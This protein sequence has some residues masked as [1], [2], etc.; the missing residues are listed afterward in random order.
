MKKLLALSLGDVKNITRDSMLLM[1]IF[2]PLLLAV[3]VRFV[4]PLAADEVLERF[5][6]DIREHYTFIMSFIIQLSPFMLGV[7]AGLMIL[8]EKDENILAQIAVTPLSTSGYIAY[9]LL[10][11]MIVSLFLTLFM[12]WIADLVTLEWKLLPIVLLVCMH[13]PIVALFL[14]GMAQN[15]VE[16]LA[17]TKGAGVVLFASLA[18]YLIPSNWAYVA[19]VFPTYWISEAFVA[20]IDGSIQTYAMAVGAGF[21]VSGAY[22]YLLLRKFKT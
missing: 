1:G 17:L 14:G 21:I 22:L 4:V 2:A 19:G 16:G 6:L 13:T 20:A 15:K 5:A 3:F 7:M 18:S 9:R 12:V 8:D 10:S 11:P